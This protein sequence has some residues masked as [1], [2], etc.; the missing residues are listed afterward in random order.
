MTFIEPCLAAQAPGEGLCETIVRE[1]GPFASGVVFGAVLAAT[2]SYLMY[3]SAS[4]HMLKRMEM[5][6]KREKTLLD[7]LS[8]KDAR[9]DAL[10]ARLA[11]KGE[12]GH[13]KQSAQSG[14][15]N[16]GHRK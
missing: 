2:L 5:D 13:S 6:A 11:N 1:C 10:H 4:N 16:K 12:S 15:H 8:Q 7:Q 9:I 14:N 3:K